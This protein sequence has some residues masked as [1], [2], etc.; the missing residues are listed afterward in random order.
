MPRA[1]SGTHFAV[2]ALVKPAMMMKA[3][4]STW[5][6]VRM[7]LTVVDSLAPR[8]L[9]AVRRR[10][11]PKAILPGARTGDPATRSMGTGN[12]TR[13]ASM[14]AAAAAAAAR[15][16]APLRKLRYRILVSQTLYARC[17]ARRTVSALLWI[18]CARPPPLPAPTRPPTHQS[19]VKVLPP[20]VAW[21]W[22]NDESLLMSTAKYGEKLRMTLA[23]AR[24]YSKSMLE[25]TILGTS[26]T[27]HA[28]L[29]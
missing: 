17:H 4:S 8:A 7:L 15:S 2:S 16:I 9:M 26:N 29:S 11:R 27:S 21:Y 5:M 13:R 12:D 24:M 25:V 10:V 3:I 19:T 6:T 1:V 18:A 23:S 20:M 22:K 14:P 28:W